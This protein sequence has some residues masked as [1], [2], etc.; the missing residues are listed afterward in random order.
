MS[1]IPVLLNEVI[2][3]LNPQPGE[4]FIDG[5]FGGGGHSSEI[6]KRIL[7]SGKLLAVDW[8]KEMV[9]KGRKI[10]S[11]KL[12]IPVSRLRKNLILEC[13]NYADLPEILEKKKLP[14]ADG[15][16]LDLG[17]S[18]DQLKSKRGFSFMVDEPLIMTYSDEREPLWK[19]L[20]GVN[21]KQLTNIL[22]RFGGE[23]YARRI[24]KAIKESERRRKIMTSGELA[25]IVRRAVP[26]NYERG[27]ID[28]ATRTFQALRIW[29]NGELE[30][31]EK[32]LGE[33]RNILKSG[34]RAGI[35]S[36]HSLEDRLVKDAFRRGAKEGWLE[37]LNKK[38][39]IPS[40][41]ELKANIRSRSAKLRVCRII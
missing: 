31:L 23:R 19:M 4:F 10:I 21:E 30:N 40:E 6:L 38:P 8:D 17:F 25:E 33:L 39:V 41:N 27:R 5:T 37:I 2:G 12:Q 32:I 34:G 14:K 13:G 35:I 9:A 20:H 22:Y 28:P 7:P 29:A 1:H 15:L 16:L 24:A 18:S 26:G 36:F 11:D 3:L